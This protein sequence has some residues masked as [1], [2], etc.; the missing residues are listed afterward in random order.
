V[1]AASGNQ[2]AAM[3][4]R[5]GRRA[6]ES[7]LD[8][9][10]GGI[11][12]MHARHDWVDAARGIGIIAVV[13]GHVW[14]RGELR[15]IAYAFHMPFFFLLSG[16]L[17]TGAR[18]PLAFARRQVAVQ[19]LSYACW[20]LLVLGLDLLVE[21]VR[22]HR[23]IFHDWPHDL[24]PLLLG[25]IWLKGPFTVFWFVPCLVVA[26]IVQNGLTARWPVPLSP[27]WLAVAGLSLA[28]AYGLGA[29]TS[30]SPL[31]LLAVPMALFLLWA[32]AAWRAIG[33]DG[34]RIAPLA[35]IAVAGL[36]FAPPV[37]MKAGD[38]GW[39]V[40]SIAVA[41]AMSFLIFRAARSPLLNRA[42]LRQVGRASLVVMYLHVPVIHYLTPYCGK[43]A[44][45]LLGLAIPLGA[46]RLFGQARLTRR[47]F[48]A[49]G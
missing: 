30:T 35:P 37:N 47:L 32:G 46:W 41:I 19:G 45:M 24:L 18:P 13:M 28:A 36:A 17:V 11:G 9:A 48:L 8:P 21:G 31:G 43:P 16:W 33:W 4:H 44:L 6:G 40:V 10:I 5:G 38:Y 23:P 39:P 49:E 27:P 2:G 22:G 20:L 26:R 12:A 29:W 25:G 3:A 14:T 7:V 1:E 15:H 34:W 42:P